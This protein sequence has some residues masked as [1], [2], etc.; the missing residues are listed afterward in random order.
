MSENGTFVLYIPFLL[1]LLCRTSFTVLYYIILEILETQ[2]K[3]RLRLCTY[4]ALIDNWI[5]TQKSK[6]V[7]FYF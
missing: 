6:S 2:V 5:I 4:N 3:H 7:L 1:C